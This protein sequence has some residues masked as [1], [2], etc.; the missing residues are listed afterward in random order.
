MSLKGKRIILG[1]TGSIAAYKSAFLTRLLVK[2]GAEVQIIMS[3]SAL[4]FITPLTLSTLSKRPVLHQFQKDETGEWNNHVDLGLWADLILVA[5]I[6]AN[7][8]AKF[9]NGIC[10]NLL[11]AVYL[12][13]KCP[14]MVAP[15]MDLD[16]YQHPSV[17]KNIQTL[18]NF[19][20][21]IL[22]A[23]SG[24]LAS[25][26]SGQGRMMEP[27]H[28]LE[29]LFKFF[30]KKNDFLGKKV[31]ITMGPTQEAIDPVRYISN[32]SSGKMGYALAESFKNRG[33]DVYVVSGPVSIPIEKE[34]FQW[35]DVKSA[36]EM[37]D[38]AKSFHTDC[39]YAVFTAAVADYG[40]AE[41]APEKIK[42]NDS[43][44]SIQLKKNVD[45]AQSLGA[46]KSLNQIHVGFALE[47][48]NESENAQAKLK[49]KNFDLI[50]LNSMKEK[51]AGFR[52]DTNK[53][54]IFTN[55][56]EK[57]ESPLAPKTEIAEFILDEIKKL[58][59]WE[60]A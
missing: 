51:G 59:L 8:L 49:K 25:G 58:E 43:Q 35:V 10:D 56:A 46:N 41:V 40:P 38:A 16:M 13:A 5:P 29:E 44:M 17:L 47:T 37:Y 18:S 33:A 2:E 50:V 34:K 60:E 1:V 39:D 20:N 3:A 42:K 45:I 54:T 14:V 52:L 9:A 24:E 6:S 7:T 48:E 19:G 23:E 21:Y 28:I 36:Q 32:H 11:T 26:L 12:S 15:A 57:I 55:K 4:D 31:L 30:Q 22:E 27:E 53:V